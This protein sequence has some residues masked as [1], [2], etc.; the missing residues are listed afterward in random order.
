MSKIAEA[1]EAAQ[2]ADDAWQAEI[3][4]VFGKNKAGDA[5]Y[6]DRGKSTPELLALNTAKR[7]ADQVLHSLFEESRQEARDS[8]RLAD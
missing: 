4:R 3:D 1:Y 2:A 7:A 6:D 8:R 5:R